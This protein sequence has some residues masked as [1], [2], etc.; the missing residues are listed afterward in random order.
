MKSKYK[1]NNFSETPLCH[2]FVKWAGGK[3]QLLPQLCT[4]APT[5]FDGYLE[6][7]LGGGAM[8]FCL[9]SDK[10]KR[11]TA[12]YIS[13]IN[14][15]LINAY[16][17]VRDETEK[18]INLLIEHQIRYRKA[19]KEYYNKL[20]DD[21]NSIRKDRS[22]NKL[23]R[24]A[25]FIA[26]NK[27]CFNGLHRVNQKGDFNV[28]LGRYKNPL[29]CDVSNIRN[30]SFALRH[31]NATIKACDYREMVKNAK[32]GDFIYLD[33]PYAP[34][35][36]TAYFT[37]YT[38]SAFS[39][40]DQKELSYVFRELDNRGCKV[41]LTNSSTP[42]VRELYADFAKNTVEFGSKRTIN[43]NASKRE[44][45]TDLIIRNYS[46]DNFHKKI[47]GVI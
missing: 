43:C 7:F 19:P 9:I 26:L 5:E 25:Q 28:P 34:L 11:I 15:E 18:L 22:S 23:E 8:F 40:Q 32:Q 30:V 10:N 31:P 37:G 2:P 12:Y 33:P 45:H 3:R 47:R 20:R 39:Y 4:F 42:L 29:I 24:A 16:I 27:T 21:Y 17:A 38:S 35:S 44:G 36:N 13:D 41:L 46:E 6:P 1:T 14:S